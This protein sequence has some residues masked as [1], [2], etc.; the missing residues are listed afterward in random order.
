MEELKIIGQDNLLKLINTFT[1]NTIPRTLLFIGEEGCGKHLFTKYLAN[2]L[3]LEIVNLNELNSEELAD[4]LISFSQNPIAKFY[5]INLSE[6]D[7]K[8]QNKYL[9]FIEEPSNTTYILLLANSEVDVLYT[10]LNRSR[11]LYFE[12]YTKEQLKQFSWAPSS[13]DYDDLIYSI[14]KTPGKLLNLNTDLIPETVALCDTILNKSKLANYPNI[15]KI[16]T[17]INCKDNSK[18]IDYE[19][20]FKVLTRLS[21]E[22]YKNT[23]DNFS[24]NLYLY[25]KKFSTMAFNK[26]VI[27]EHWM[28]MFLNK[29]WELSR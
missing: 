12:P 17:K 19:I 5:I 15:I 4:T 11:K 23:N 26:T 18:K 27:K 6:I 22:N 20:F 21:F 25:L 29:L 10:I 13:S 7:L 24:L 9:K 28:L 14:C 16:I 2:K 1:L 8:T 3:Q